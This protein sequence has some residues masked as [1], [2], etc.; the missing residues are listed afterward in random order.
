KMSNRVDTDY[1]RSLDL[2]PFV[3]FYSDRGRHQPSAFLATVE[4]IAEW[5][6]KQRLFDFTL[7]RAAFE[8]FLVQHKD[9]LQQIVR[10]T[11]G[12]LKA[13]HAIKKFFEFVLAKV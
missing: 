5:E 10:S 12:G 7:N 9:F 13:V 8:N 4:L 6:D 11:R 3:Y 1:M 2:H